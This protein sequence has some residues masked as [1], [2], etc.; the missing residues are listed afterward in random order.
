MK[1][2][3]R[4]IIRLES[5]DS[6]NNYAANLIKKG[7]LEHGAVIMAVEQTG[8]RGQ[9]GSEWLV[10]PGENLTISIF[11]D[12]VNLS[13]DNQFFLTRLASLSIVDF[14]AK[15][16]IQGTIKWP[17]DIYVNGKKIAGILIENN[18]S[19][20]TIRKSVIGI[21]LNVNQ[22]D[23]GEL[24]A[25]SL[26]LETQQYRS[27]E[28]VVF[29]LIKCFNERMANGLTSGRLEY[30][31]LEHMHLLNVKSTFKD[32]DGVFNGTIIGVEP[33]GHLKVER[34]DEI[35]MYSLKEIIFLN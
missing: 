1:Q 19:G 23:F 14:L 28:E 12:E 11:L 9:I 34:K 5:V 25:S 27:I 32:K 15:I 24:N 4:K 26:I 10:K 16:N 18:L 22:K 20:T 8:G 21:G 17:N 3:G 30:D 6:T 2:I 29:S 7:E 33:T 13:V 35:R 31:Y